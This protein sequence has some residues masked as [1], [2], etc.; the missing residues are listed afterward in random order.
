MLHKLF[1]SFSAWEDCEK[2]VLYAVQK[3]PSILSTYV[4]MKITVPRAVEEVGGRFNFANENRRHVVL[5]K[6][7]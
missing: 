3:P 7:Q 1:P 4:D 6:K 5:T 2:F